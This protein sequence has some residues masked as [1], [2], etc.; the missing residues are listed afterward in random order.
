LNSIPAAI[1]KSPIHGGHS[2]RL[3]YHNNKSQNKSQIEGSE[4]KNAAVFDRLNR[5]V[6][7]KD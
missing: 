7:A 3:T 2:N 5:S 6:F 4:N 1:S